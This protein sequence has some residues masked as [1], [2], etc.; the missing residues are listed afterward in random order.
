MVERRRVVATSD[1]K[2]VAAMQQC[3]SWSAVIAM[4]NAAGSAWR[5]T[6]A[7]ITGC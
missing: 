5:S 7:F 2:V 1:G 3:S 4:S 6:A